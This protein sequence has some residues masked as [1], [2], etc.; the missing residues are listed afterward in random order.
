MTVQQRDLPL[1]FFTVIISLFCVAIAFGGIKEAAKWKREAAM[2]RIELR[3]AGEA[4]EKMLAPQIVDMGRLLDEVRVHESVDGKHLYGDAKFGRCGQSV[5]AYHMR[6]STLEWLR[7]AHNFPAPRGCEAQRKFLLN[8]PDA[9][10]AAEF[11]LTI[12]LSKTGDLDLALCLYN[13]GHNSSIKVCTYS[14][15]VRKG[16]SA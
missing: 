7:F 14:G 10:S 5:G 15:K 11:Y 3:D 1:I 13:A 6:V 9:R 16:T 8:E 2:L 12:L 4:Y